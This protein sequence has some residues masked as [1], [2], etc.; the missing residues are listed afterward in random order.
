MNYLRLWILMYLFKVRLNVLTCQHSCTITSLNELLSIDLFNAEILKHKW[1][2]FE[3][4]THST[5]PFHLTIFRFNLIKTH[6]S[7]SFTIVWENAITIKYPIIY[8][9]LIVEDICLARL[10]FEKEIHFQHNDSK[11][12]LIKFRSQLLF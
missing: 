4:T 2:Q 6:L 10:S 8:C 5:F 11:F 12:H 3:N 7:Y 9:M 1:F